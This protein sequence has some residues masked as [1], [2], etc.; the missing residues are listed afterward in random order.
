MKLGH[1]SQ[2]FSLNLHNYAYLVKQLQFEKMINCGIRKNSRKRDRLKK[3]AIQSGNPNVWNKYTFLMNKVNNKKK[4][5]MELF[6]NNFDII[7]P[8]LYHRVWFIFLSFG[9]MDFIVEL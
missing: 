8:A 6:Y 5:A 1:Y 7:V 9:T 4:H 2:I 3:K